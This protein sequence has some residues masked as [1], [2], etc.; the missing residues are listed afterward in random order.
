M[1]PKMTEAQFKEWVEFNNS[2]TNCSCDYCKEWA[3]EKQKNLQAVEFAFSE[4]GHEFLG[5]I[6]KKCKDVPLKDKCEKCKF[7]AKEIG[8]V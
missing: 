8:L 6:D 5:L 7:I 1:K 4:G 2:P 3:K